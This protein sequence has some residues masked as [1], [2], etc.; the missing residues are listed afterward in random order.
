M[1]V[2]PISILADASRGLMEGERGGS[3]IAISLAVA[4]ALTR[5]SRRSRRG[6]T[7]V[8]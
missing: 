1:N 8:R 6:C 3:D 5:S 2:N 4:A 7:G